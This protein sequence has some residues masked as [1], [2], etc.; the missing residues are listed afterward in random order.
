MMSS[1]LSNDLD[2]SVRLRIPRKKAAQRAAER[3]A[4]RAAKRAEP[5][6]EQVPT[7]DNQP[8]DVARSR[9]LLREGDLL[10]RYGFQDLQRGS[11][12]GELTVHDLA[13]EVEE[14]L[15][16][17][18]RP[19]GVLS[20][21]EELATDLAPVDEQVGVVAGEGLIVSGDD[22]GDECTCGCCS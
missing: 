1:T 6:R 7:L 16:S 4:E 21:E 14:A 5:V 19:G 2:S 11:P 10:S 15:V 18:E 9:R 13:R 22:P 12:F 20:D 3:A 17:E 8:L